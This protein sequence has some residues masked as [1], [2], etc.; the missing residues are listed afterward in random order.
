MGHLV[1]K[2]LNKTV[3]FFSF[4]HI[5]NLKP[6]AHHSSGLCRVF[7]IQ[8]N[9]KHW[10]GN[11][12]GCLQ[13]KCQ[14]YLLELTIIFSLMFLS[15][16]SFH[17]LFHQHIKLRHG[18]INPTFFSLLCHSFLKLFSVK[19]VPFLNGSFIEWFLERGSGSFHQ[20]LSSLVPQFSPC[21]RLILRLEG[22]YDQ[23]LPTEH[24]I[25]VLCPF[26][27]RISGDKEITGPV[28]FFY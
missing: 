16:F 23:K 1:K 25:M 7:L 24:Q 22:V 12:D 15:L 21:R 26:H 11:I 17:Q 18:G 5:K 3:F 19:P 13:S 9:N 6:H 20:V 28:K 8:Y 4:L 10:L 14:C 2:F 27:V